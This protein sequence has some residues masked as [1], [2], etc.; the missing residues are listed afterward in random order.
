[1]AA[2]NHSAASNNC[3]DSLVSGR[4]TWGSA[5]STRPLSPP[6]APTATGAGDR[7]RNALNDL[8]RPN[9]RAHPP[10]NSDDLGQE[11]DCLYNQG[12]KLKPQ[13]KREKHN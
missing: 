3:I 6:P 9:G 13:M 12:E 2:S 11:I 4:P 10:S 1:M 7:D 8:Q 5:V